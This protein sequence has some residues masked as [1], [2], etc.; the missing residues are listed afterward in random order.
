MVDKIPISF[1][2]KNC[3]AIKYHLAMKKQYI[4]ALK[5]DNFAIFQIRTLHRKEINIVKK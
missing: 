3:L 1:I 2:F 4:L 5:I